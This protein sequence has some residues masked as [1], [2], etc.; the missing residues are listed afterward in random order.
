[1]PLSKCE[2]YFDLPT[3][4]LNRAQSVIT[5]DDF[6]DVPQNKAVTR[7]EGFN[8]STSAAQQLLTTFA[9]GLSFL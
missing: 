5:A 3:H 9:Q 4:S 7:G 1:M 2:C 6:D 8:E